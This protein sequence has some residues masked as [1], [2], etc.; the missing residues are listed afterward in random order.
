MI[1]YYLHV[2]WWVI[3]GFISGGAFTT[4]SNLVLLLATHLNLLLTVFY[5]YGDEI[6]FVK[7]VLHYYIIVLHLRKKSSDLT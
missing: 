5:S 1:V 2:S 3:F 4:T 7:L 6:S